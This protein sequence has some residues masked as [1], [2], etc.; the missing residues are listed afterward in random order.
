MKEFQCSSCHNTLGL[1]DGLVFV[2]GDTRIENALTLYC[3]R[4][5]GARVWRPVLK[6][7]HKEDKQRVKYASRIAPLPLVLEKR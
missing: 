1:T 5:D 6:G 4:C 3:M 2:I 7:T